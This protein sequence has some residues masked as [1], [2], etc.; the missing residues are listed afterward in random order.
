M[1]KLIL[2][3]L[4]GVNFVFANNASDVNASNADIYPK[5]W[6]ADDIEF[7][8]AKT[9]NW[10]WLD[11]DDTITMCDNGYPYGFP[12]NVCSML[13]ALKLYDA[14]DKAKNTRKS[15]QAMKEFCYYLLRS[16]ENEKNILI[17]HA[18]NAR[19]YN[20][21]DLEIIALPSELKMLE[22]KCAKQVD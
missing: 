7:Y 4:L 21:D 11:V 6:T 18:F 9:K 20:L 12:Y 13:K 22:T 15:K 2:V 8:E 16:G 17:N 19:N 3:G 10:S 1:K 14:Y 5:E